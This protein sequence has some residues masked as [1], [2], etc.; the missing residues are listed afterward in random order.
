MKWSRGLI[1]V[2]GVLD[3]SFDKCQMNSSGRNCRTSQGRLQRQLNRVWGRLRIY[4]NSRYYHPTSVIFDLA[5][6]HHDCHLWKGIELATSC[7]AFL[8]RDG[9]PRKGTELVTVGYPSRYQACWVKS[10]VPHS[11]SAVNRLGDR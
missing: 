10:S 2:A 9:Y 1:D 8:H 11:S 4:R 6:L 3:T 7:L 5:F